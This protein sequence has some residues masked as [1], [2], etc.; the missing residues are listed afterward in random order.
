MRIL[1]PH[2][3]HSPQI[4]EHDHRCRTSI[5]NCG[6]DSSEAFWKFHNKKVLEKTAEKFKI[7]TGESGTTTLAPNCLLTLLVTLPSRRIGQ[8]MT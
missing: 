7:G 6:K 3:V 5:R 1:D 8:A 4:T 2:L